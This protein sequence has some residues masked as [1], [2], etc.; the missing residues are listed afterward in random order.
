MKKILGGIALS[1]FLAAPA[2]A[3]D[4][5]ARM[6]VKTQPPVVVAAYDWSG[7]YIG[8]H[9]GYGSGRVRWADVEA[10][11][12]SPDDDTT[13]GEGPQHRVSGAVAGGH[14]GFQRQWNNIVLGVEF[15]G[16][17]SGMKANSLSTEGVMDDQLETKIGS[18]LQLVARL[19]IA[20]GMWHG[21]VKG[22]WAGAHVKINLVDANDAIN[23]TSKQWHH[24]FVVGTGLEY[25]LAPNWIAGVDY[26]FIGLQDK[27]HTLA[28]A[29]GDSVT[30][31]VDP[32]HIHVI[33]G[34]LSYKFGG[35]V[36]ARY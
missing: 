17:W 14:I 36:V 11:D 13:D 34:R 6:P 22:G 12:T 30:Y 35:P 10:L 18:I 29:P 26:S 2:M 24:G 15:S 9:G 31:N 28:M 8:A 19:G 3:A 27:N 25:A 7:F 4:L 16:A 1:A 23:T 33:V 32:R 5:P 20:Q 21:Y